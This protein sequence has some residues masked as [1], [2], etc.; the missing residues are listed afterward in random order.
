MKTKKKAR[1][2]KTNSEL[3]DASITQIRES[4]LDL[5]V[6][7]G[8]FATTM[9]QI[10]AGAGLTKGGVY[11]YV[12]KKE[13]ILIDLLESIEHSYLTIAVDSIRELDASY[14]ERIV[15]LLH[16]QVTYALERPQDIM[17]L[18][19]MSVELSGKSSEPARRIEDIYRRLHDFVQRTI[20]DGAEAGEIKT[21][22]P[23]REMAS[24]YIAAHDG[25]MLEWSRR[26]RDIS[27]EALVRV[28][29][30]LFVGGLDA[31]G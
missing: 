29:R 6:T 23:P 3:R 2:R 19:M 31:R 22:L 1:G 16:W 5:F 11:F 28:F 17:L 12:P 26:Q 21:R 27:G 15:R 10:A 18:V 24:F 4:A 13:T 14:K 30:E 7:R 20:Q 8:Y 25:V 9:E